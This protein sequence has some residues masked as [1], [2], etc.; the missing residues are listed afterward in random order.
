[1]A[2]E[3]LRFGGGEERARGGEGVGVEGLNVEG[4]E[5]DLWGAGVS[6]VLVR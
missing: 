2:R 3:V 6:S 4:V 1:M 5:V